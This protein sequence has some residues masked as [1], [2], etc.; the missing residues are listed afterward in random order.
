M[1]STLIGLVQEIALVHT[2]PADHSV[3]GYFVYGSE[4]W[5]NVAVPDDKYWYCYISD[6]LLKFYGCISGTVNVFLL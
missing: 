1:L 3:L 4:W 6:I 5:Q 2:C